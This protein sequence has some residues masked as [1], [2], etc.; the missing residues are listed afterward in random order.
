[1]LS[2]RET[3]AT[4]DGTL[5]SALVQV[6]VTVVGGLL[7][8]LVGP[9][10][11]RRTG[12]PY[13][14]LGTTIVAVATLVVARAIWVWAVPRF[15]RRRNNALLEATVRGPF[16]G[17]AGRFLEAMSQSFTRGAGSILNSLNSAKAIDSRFYNQCVNH[18]ATLGGATRWLVRRATLF[19][20]PVF[21]IGDGRTA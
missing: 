19:D 1:M 2:A 11:S 21:T 4:K 10:L 5:R 7:L 16:L 6:V 12:I 18:F 13:W 9:L 8:E 17:I 3:Q 15:R 20:G 14:I